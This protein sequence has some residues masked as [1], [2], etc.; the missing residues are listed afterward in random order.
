[1]GQERTSRFGRGQ[2]AKRT[3]VTGAMRRAPAQPR[4][5]ESMPQD[6][7]DL[8][9]Q[10]GA[11]EDLSAQRDSDGGYETLVMPLVTL[12]TL[13]AVRAVRGAA[14]GEDEG[15]EAVGEDDYDEYEVDPSDDA[16]FGRGA[17]TGSWVTG[18]RRAAT[19]ARAV[20]RQRVALQRSSAPAVA[21]S[22]PQHEPRLPVRSSASLTERLKRLHALDV[23]LV[24]A[25]KRVAGPSRPASRVLGEAADRFAFLRAHRVLL[26][27]LTVVTVLSVTVTTAVSTGQVAAF[28]AGSSWQTL[29]GSGIAPTPTPRPAPDIVDAGHYVAK[30]GF[31]WPA[32][33]RALPEDERQR[34]VFM[35]PAAYKAASAYDQRYHQSMEP[36]LI[37]WWTH[38]EGIGARIN[39]SNCANRPTR[40]GTN[41]FT[42]I[43]NCPVANFWQLGYGNQFSVIYVLKNAFMDLYG[44]PNDTKL[45]QK[46][47]QWVLDF[48]QRQGTVP[49]CGG[50][51]CTFPEKTIDQISA[52]INQNTGAVTEDNWWASVLSRDPAINCYMVAHAL[53]FFNH[54]ATRNWVGC[55]Y[56]EPCWGYESNRLGDILSAWPGLRRAANIEG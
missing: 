55:Y 49:K 38:A 1:M 35:L 51:S 44:N 52:G 19:Q 10:V 23:M 32:D 56:A 40:P 27:V 7:D 3:I 24:P 18:R 46:V 15:A 34:I 12:P 29:S 47:G 31:D 50:Y 36:E 8:D 21:R 54:N 26:V 33:T 2:S 14:E 22:A 48:D 11:D 16:L 37:V 9:G 25:G 6:S 4:A 43:E 45:V 17:W 28:L 53:T 13:P 5:P 20:A 39:Y 30:Y 42:N 41:Y